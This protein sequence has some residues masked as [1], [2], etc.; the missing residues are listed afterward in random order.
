LAQRDALTGLLNRSGFEQQMEQVVADGNGASVALLYIDLDHFKP[1]NDQYGHPV[2]DQVLQQFG[3]R[4][5]ALVRPSDSVARL[6]GDEFAILLTDVR[7]GANA[8]MVA[9]KVIAAAHAPFAVA[10]H[11]LHIGASV[12]VAFGADAEAGWPDL[13]KRADA[14]LYEAKNTG[15]GRQAGVER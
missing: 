5:S 11:V 2:G 15:R 4:L 10:E 8:S 1:V 13:V 6:G 7:A 12:G 14:M 3:Q 9:D